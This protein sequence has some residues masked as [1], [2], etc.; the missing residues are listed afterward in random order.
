MPLI[1]STLFSVCLSPSTLTPQMQRGLALQ[2][3]THCFVC[4]NNVLPVCLQKLNV[5]MDLVVSG[6]S[7]L[8]ERMVKLED[9]PAQVKQ[10]FKDVGGQISSFRKMVLQV[11]QPVVH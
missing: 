5:K 3:C 7:D 1:V 2:A 6:I 11:S 4:R 9:L 8:K 10:G